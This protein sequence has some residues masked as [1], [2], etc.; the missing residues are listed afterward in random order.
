MILGQPRTGTTILFDLL[1]QD[2]QFRVPLTWEVATP[3]PPPE[4][5]TYLT[6]A[7]IAEAQAR[8]AM[9]E[10]LIP[11]FQ[12]IHPSGAQR[13]QECV[14][15]TA[16]DFRSLL[17]PTVYHIPSY[18]RWLLWE[19]D[20]APAYRYHRRFLQLL[21]WRHP[22]SRWLLKTPG[23]QWCLEALF[24]E[25]P[26]ASIIHTH[27]DPLKVL[28]SV[29]SLT[30]NLQLMATETTSVPM[31]AS[32]WVDYLVEGNDRSVAAR[33]DGT[34]PE[35]A[36]VDVAFAAL[37]DDTFGA[38][39]SIYQ[40]LGL[41]LT[42]EAQ[43]RMRSFLR[44]NP[45][46]KHG[47]HAYTFSATELDVA[48]VRERRRATSSSSMSPE[49]ALGDG[50]R[51]ESEAGL[52]LDHAEV[53]LGRIDVGLLADEGVLGAGVDV[54]E[55][56]LEPAAVADRGGAGGEVRPLR[57][58]PRGF[59]GVGGRHAEVGPDRRRQC[60]ARRRRPLSRAVNASNTPARAA[61]HMPVKWAKF[62]W[63]VGRRASGSMS[64]IRVLVMASSAT[65]SS[66]LL[67]TPAPSRRAR[68]R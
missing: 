50:R 33:H 53:D 21:Q 15:I 63:N 39:S 40:Q 25:Y 52:V 68:R 51:L 11:G 47:T 56:T 36:A 42:D 9:S 7:R 58:L 3:S 48:A 20:M 66:M 35:G 54:A 26:D 14:A 57:D 43:G 49:K 29:A 12:A 10:F 55:R 67:A 60:L 37:M 62:R 13:A 31:L 61:R 27:R 28:A 32:E 6:D 4:T 18:A 17:F 19:A 2:P 59:G 64:D 5:A 45:S 46:D 41:E 22:G 24:N 8:V 65:S 44:E 23:H 1:A 34:V 38:I 16:G 30:A